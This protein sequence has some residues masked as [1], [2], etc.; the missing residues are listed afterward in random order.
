MSNSDTGD[1]LVGSC[2]LIVLA[3]MILSMGACTVGLWRGACWSDYYGS[4]PV[5]PILIGFIFLGAIA[6]GWVGALIVTAVMGPV[7]LIGC[8]ERG[9]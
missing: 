3:L 4:H 8:W 2:L 7:W 6:G 1:T 5:T 9:R